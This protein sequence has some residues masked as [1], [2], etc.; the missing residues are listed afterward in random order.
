M[1]QPL[2]VEA[3]AVVGAAFG[4]GYYAGLIRIGAWWGFGA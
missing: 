1:S 4:G 2:S 3:P